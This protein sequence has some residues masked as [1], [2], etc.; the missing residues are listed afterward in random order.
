MLVV[1]GGKYRV[2]LC[3]VSTGVV[4]IVGRG[5]DGVAGGKKAHDY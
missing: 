5:L 2:S 4:T 1:V 3:S